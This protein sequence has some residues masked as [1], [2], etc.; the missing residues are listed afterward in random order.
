MA[1][2]VPPRAPGTEPQPPSPCR[3]PAAETPA[4]GA[5]GGG[6]GTRTLWHQGGVSAGTVVPTAAPAILRGVIPLVPVRRRLPGPRTAED[7]SKVARLSDGRRVTG[8]VPSPGGF[9]WGTAH[10]PCITR[11]SLAVADGLRVDSRELPGVRGVGGAGGR[12]HVLL[13]NLPLLSLS[14][15]L[16]N[17][18]NFPRT[19]VSFPVKEPVGK[20]A[21]LRTVA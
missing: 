18:I 4:A 13:R 8:V 3:L 16:P 19:H 5:A 17:Q 1:A 11:V 14:D 9:P 21:A 12:E 7:L 10:T 15:N 6:W 20:G 2:S